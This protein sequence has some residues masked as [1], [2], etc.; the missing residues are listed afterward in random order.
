LLC[1]PSQNPLGS[2]EFPQP[3]FGL[4]DIISIFH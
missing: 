4:L 3:H 1:E 2:I